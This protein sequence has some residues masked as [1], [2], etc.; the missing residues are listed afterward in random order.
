MPGYKL[1]TFPDPKLDEQIRLLCQAIEDNTFTNIFQENTFRTNPML[2]DG[3]VWRGSS[4]FV[5]QTGSTFATQVFSNYN[6]ATDVTQNNTPIY[7]QANDPDGSWQI[8][9]PADAINSALIQHVV[10]GLA[11]ASA[12]ANPD[13]GHIQPRYNPY[14]LMNF[15]TDLDVTGLF[16]WLGF[17]VNG[18]GVTTV[19]SVPSIPDNFIGLHWQGTGFWEYIVRINSVTTVL[20]TLPIAAV[21]QTPYVFEMQIVR[22]SRTNPTHAVFFQLREEQISSNGLIGTV[23]VIPYNA[24]V[25]LNGTTPEFNPNSGLTLHH[26]VYNT[27]GTVCR[28]KWRYS[29]F[30]TFRGTDPDLNNPY[31]FLKRRLT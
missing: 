23:N 25:S 12:T 8:M 31:D 6:C 28:L 4:G 13:I 16:F 11:A 10:S 2:I 22:T 24:L 20:Y 5:G 30:E 7:A 14:L 18:G 27:D 3:V 1:Y 21:A 29:Y 9:R 26:G 19:G 15:K 17:R